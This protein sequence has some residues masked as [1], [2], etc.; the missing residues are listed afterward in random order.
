MKIKQKKSTQGGGMLAVHFDDC[1]NILA[2]H[3]KIY[4]QR[5]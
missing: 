5:L 4:L 3:G 1:D 2:G